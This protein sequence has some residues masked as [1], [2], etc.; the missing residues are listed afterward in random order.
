MLEGD[1]KKKSSYEARIIK[2]GPWPEHEEAPPLDPLLEVVRSFCEMYGSHGFDSG[3]IIYERFATAQRGNRYAQYTI[4]E[5]GAIEGVAYCY[6]VPTIG[7]INKDRRDAM[8]QAYK[9]LG[10]VKKGDHDP[11]DCSALGHL[12]AFVPKLLI[13]VESSNKPSPGG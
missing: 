2:L 5:I 12:I 4:R 13:A 10:K 8:P 6:D 11:D 9:M 7:R 3:V 1:P